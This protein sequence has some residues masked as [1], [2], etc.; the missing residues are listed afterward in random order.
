MKKILKKISSVLMA[1]T[2]LGAGM[3]IDSHNSNESNSLVVSARNEYCSHYLDRYSWT[4]WD[5]V[6]ITWKGPHYFDEDFVRYCY[7]AR[8]GRFL[9]SEYKTREWYSPDKEYNSYGRYDGTAININ[10]Y[11]RT[12]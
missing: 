4:E 2:I 1:F 11:Y 12:Y 5:Y 3:A 6:G 8:C 10:T 9:Q 7:C